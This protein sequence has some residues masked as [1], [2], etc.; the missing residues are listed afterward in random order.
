MFDAKVNGHLDI[1]YK[2]VKIKDLDNIKK[3]NC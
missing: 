1:M 2:P 3:Y